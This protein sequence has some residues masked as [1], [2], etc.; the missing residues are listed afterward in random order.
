LA[1]NPVGIAVDM[2][3]MPSV[4]SMTHQALISDEALQ[5]SGHKV[6]AKMCFE[7]GATNA[8]G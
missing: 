8:E 4:L 7:I 3:I 1:L 5:A 2:A 6:G